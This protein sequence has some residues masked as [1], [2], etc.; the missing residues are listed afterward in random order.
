[1]HPGNSFYKER[2]R[3]R[4]GGNEFLTNVKRKKSKTGIARYIVPRLK[5]VILKIGSNQYLSLSSVFIYL[6]IIL[7][8]LK[9]FIK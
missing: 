3:E 8:T 6:V 7:L 9:Q 5:I 1:M 2:E 4:R